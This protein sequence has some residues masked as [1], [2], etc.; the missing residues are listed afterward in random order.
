[1]FLI[2]LRRK[3]NLQRVSVAREKRDFRVGNIYY[4]AQ[5]GVDKRKIFIDKKDCFR[6]ITA[7]E[8]FNSRENT[9]LWN[10][11]FHKNSKHVKTAIYKKRIENNK[12]RRIVDF[13]AFVMKPNS[14]DFL[15]REIR[16]GGI[17]LF[18]KKIGGYAYYFNQRYKRRGTLFSSRY[19]AF[20][21]EREH[22]RNAFCYLHTKPAKRWIK[23]GFPE[24]DILEKLYRYRC[25]SLLDYIGKHNF[26]SVT[27]RGFFLEIF[28]GRKGVKRQMQSWIKNIDKIEKI[29]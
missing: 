27:N 29:M 23:S 14:Y 3:N 25:S 11:F 4:I 9:N 6:F 7:L 8:F 19:K 21:M 16:E 17:S 28:G 2:T 10:L 13:L 26:P 15:L 1:M 20:N 18:M 5:R 22:F 24:E 12:K